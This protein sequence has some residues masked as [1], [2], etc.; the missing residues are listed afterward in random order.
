MSNNICF[1]VLPTLSHYNA[2]WGL[3]NS[4]KKNDFNVFMTCTNNF[5]GYIINLGY[6]PVKLK[7]WEEYQ[8]NSLRTFLKLLVLNA[9]SNVKRARY[10]NFIDVMNDIRNNIKTI[11]PKEIIID[12]HLSYYYAFLQDFNIPIKIVETKLV[13]T[14]Y[15]FIPPMYLNIV[16]KNN[17]YYYIIGEMYWLRHKIKVNLK[18]YI[19]KLAFVGVDS[20]FFIKRTLKNKNLSF[21]KIFKKPS[22]CSFNYLELEDFI[23]KLIVSPQI[24]EYPWRTLKP[25]E[26]Y[27]E[28]ENFK[29]SLK[30]GKFIDVENFIIEFLKC[31]EENKSVKLIYCSFGSITSLDKKIH[32]F[33]LSLLN[34]VNQNPDWW[35][36]LSISG[37][38]ADSFKT[39]VKKSKIFSFVPQTAILEYCDVVI[40]HGGVNTIKE[41]LKYKMPLIIFPKDLNFDQPGNAA[42]V[43]FHNYGEIGHFKNFRE[44]KLISMLKHALLKC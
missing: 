35:L 33:Y 32:N 22:I 37:L 23:D 26:Y 2:I 36:L 7:Y 12:A 14:K 39:T 38:S 27:F 25:N 44:K 11:N 3:A 16:S 9:F 6:I 41:C 31:K 21:E 10:K 8:I 19:V 15:R 34:I 20:I 40:T 5:N 4:Y 1:I 30:N 24:L 18:H 43:A 28:S 17:L 42:R 29:A 13:T